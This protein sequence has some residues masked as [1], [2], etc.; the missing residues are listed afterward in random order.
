MQNSTLFFEHE[1]FHARVGHLL[2]GLTEQHHQDDPFD[3]FNVN[4]RA[5]KGQ[6]S[7]D[8]DFTLRRR[9]DA[10]LLQV[11]NKAA[12]GCI[13]TF[14]FEVVIDTSAVRCLRMYRLSFMVV[15]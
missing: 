14:E 4:I 11:G 15:G 3:L 2:T 1:V 7:I 12:A 10:D 9:Q 8:E 13:E 6:D 5:L